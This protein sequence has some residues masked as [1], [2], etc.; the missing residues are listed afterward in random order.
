[1]NKLVCLLILS[2][3]CS[4]CVGQNFSNT[5]FESW[6]IPNVCEINTISDNWS[7]YTTAGI[8]PDEANFSICPTTIPPSASNG[9][10]YARCV[11]FPSGGEGMFQMVS[12]FVAGD[13]YQISF[14][15]SGSNLFGGSGDIQWHLFIDDV[16]MDQTPVFQSTDAF[17]TTHTFNFAASMATHKIGVRLFLINGFDGSGAI[18]NFIVPNVT[19]IEN[20][21]SNLNILVFPNPIS[22]NIN[23]KVNNNLASEILLYDITSKILFQKQFTNSVSLETEEL[24]KGLYFYELRNKNRVIKKGKVVKD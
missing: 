24:A 15:Y 5:S 6:G 14:D 12:G 3:A 8:D 16:D 18:D 13:I 17:W 19:A 10:V 4:I 22:C 23:I 20:H 2:V 9:N 11:A 7:S 1:M 21:I